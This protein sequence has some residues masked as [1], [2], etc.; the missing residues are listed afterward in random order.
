MNEIS[1]AELFDAIR[2][3][4]AARVQSLVSAKPEL[5][6]AKNSDG[7]TAVLWAVYTRHPE[8]APA[9]LSARE[10]DFFEA[11]ALGKHDRVR[12]LLSED[13]AWAARHSGD[14]FGGLGLAVYFGHIEIARMLV[15]AAADVNSPSRNALRVSPLHSAVA[16]GS[17]ALLDLLLAHGAKADAE[18]Y[19]EATPL[20]SAA[21]AGNREMVEKLLAAG[22]DP[23]RKTR[24]GKT[25]AE[26]AREHRHEELANELANAA[27]QA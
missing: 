25:A 21:A 10:P 20:H 2:K 7:A 11:C 13:P 17:V 9:V 5:A 27:P 6:Q 1:S 3:G 24:D 16:S 26:L 14:G 23:R 18:E 15:D 4:D 22:A 8:L 12:A 19:Q